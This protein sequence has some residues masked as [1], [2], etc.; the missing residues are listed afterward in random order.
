MLLTW[1]LLRLLQNQY[2]MKNIFV[3][4]R[5]ELI[6]YNVV[7]LDFSSKQIPHHKL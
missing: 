6:S 3:V 4:N 1:E 5:I 7:Q 2:K